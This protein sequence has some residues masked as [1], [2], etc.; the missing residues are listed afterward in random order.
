MTE[1]QA[2]QTVVVGDNPILA[3]VAQAHEP[4]VYVRGAV[5]QAMLASNMQMRPVLAVSIVSAGPAIEDQML[6]FSP[7][8]DTA[9]NA[10]TALERMRAATL[11]L[12]QLVEAG[13]F[14]G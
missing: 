10:R 2:Q 9:R 4:L 5:A 3:D 6:V 13:A 1:Q 8:G 11:Q 14:D 7:G 12:E